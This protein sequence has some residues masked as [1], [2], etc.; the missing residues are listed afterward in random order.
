MSIDTARKWV[1]PGLTDFFHCEIANERQGGV[2]P[3]TVSSAIDSLSQAPDDVFDMV[4]RADLIGL[5]MIAD[6]VGT[7][8]ELRD[9]LAS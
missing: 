8:T 2:T 9:L 4:Q 6:L 1:T 7:A 3:S 5:L